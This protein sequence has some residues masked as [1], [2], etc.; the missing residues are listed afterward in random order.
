MLFDSEIHHSANM[1]CSANHYYR[2]VVVNMLDRGPPKPKEPPER[3]K[4]G[5]GVKIV[6][7]LI[8]VHV[9]TREVEDCMRSH[10]ILELKNSSSSSE[11]IQSLQDCTNKTKPG[12]RS[13]KPIC[14]FHS[15]SVCNL[16]NLL[17]SLSQPTP[18]HL[19]LPFLHCSLN[20]LL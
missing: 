16:I 5:K 9:C 10:V 20:G 6:I 15:P 11:Y 8:Y 4:E 1:H 12:S 18:I 19:R 13:S 7:F 3:R 17:E 2:A 14:H